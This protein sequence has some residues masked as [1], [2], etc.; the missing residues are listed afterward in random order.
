MNRLFT[1]SMVAAM[2]MTAVSANASLRDDLV[3][4]YTGA[5]HGYSYFASYETYVAYSWNAGEGENAPMTIEAGD[6]A[7]A[8]VLKNFFP[9]FSNIG[10]PE[11]KG[12]VVEDT[13]YDGYLGYIKITPQ[14]CGT[15]HYD[16]DGNDY[17]M[18]F[19][20]AYDS[21]GWAGYTEDTLLEADLWISSD[22]F[23]STYG[24]GWALCYLYSNGYYYYGIYGGSDSNDG[25]T[26]IEAAPSNSVR[27]QYLGK[28]NGFIV[29]DLDI[30]VNEKAQVR[31]DYDGVNNEYVEFVA[32]EGTDDIVIKNLIPTGFNY[33]SASEIPAKIFA[34][35]KYKGYSAY[36][37]IQ[38]Q[39]LGTMTIEGKEYD[40]WIGADWV[41]QSHFCTAPTEPAYFYIANSGEIEVDYTGWSLFI[42]LNGDQS[43][44]GMVFA[45]G[46]NLD[47]LYPMND[48]VKGIES[49]DE[50]DA[51]VVYYNFNGV[52][53]DGNN[54]L[55]GM[56]IKRQGSKATK[57]VVR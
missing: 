31:Y 5:D 33:I 23:I 46:Q 55:P 1:L 50:S 53:V 22:G 13:Q 54:L 45:A 43:E 3:G 20:G 57:V 6:A 40:T 10:S 19:S 37:E 47:T 4:S 48:S 44:Y 8:V 21:D 2:A 18:K 30:V 36:V 14:D 17:P 15:F 24:N 38:P 49:V 16:K 12:T 52:R 32:G 29:A 34:S 25:F 35:D 26:K 7:D 41:F 56:Y 9:G 51:P 42:D 28:Y 27:D 39:K 11:L